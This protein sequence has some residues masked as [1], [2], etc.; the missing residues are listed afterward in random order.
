[1]A[2]D[3][4]LEEKESYVVFDYWMLLVYVLSYD[5]EQ[6]CFSLVIYVVNKIDKE[7]MDID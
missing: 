7:W 5:W 6:E 4:I 3:D 2:C 1:M